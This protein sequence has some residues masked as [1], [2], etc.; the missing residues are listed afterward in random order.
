LGAEQ[1]V[2]GFQ[3]Y[4]REGKGKV[5]PLPTR[6]RKWESN[7]TT[8]H[9]SGVVDVFHSQEDGAYEF[10]SIA[11]GTRRNVSV[12]IKWHWAW[13]AYHSLLVVISLGTYPVKELASSAKIKAEVEI[14]RSLGGDG[15]VE[16]VDQ[17][18]R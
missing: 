8:V 10:R 2:L 15:F 16:F 5:D 13:V 1:E 12:N 6:R 11:L 3:I 17:G 4:K 7:H 18:C 9:D 14:V